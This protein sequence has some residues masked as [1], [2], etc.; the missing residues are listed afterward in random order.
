[1]GNS[2]NMS[3]VEKAA[4]IRKELKAIGITSNLVNVRVKYCLY[5]SVIVITIK[6]IS[7]PYAKVEALAS[8]QEHIYRCERTG[9]ILAG[10]NTYIR[11]SYSCEAEEAAMHTPR[12]KDLV[13]KIQVAKAKAE[14]TNT[15]ESIENYLIYKWSNNWQYRKNEDSCNT[16]SSSMLFF[17]PEQLAL[18]MMK[19]V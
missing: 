14:E 8:K 6:D 7:I 5:D 16:V 15:V 9:E 4:Q 13:A 2:S 19:G 12:Y 10:A 1:M 11:V 3:T 18:N 17:S